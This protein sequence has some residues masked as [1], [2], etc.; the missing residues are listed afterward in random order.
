[1]PDINSV[2]CDHII[3][4]Y[5]WVDTP[6]SHMAFVEGVGMV[7]KQCIQA[8]GLTP[9]IFKDCHICGGKAGEHTFDCTYFLTDH[10]QFTQR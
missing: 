1:M 7:C 10:K 2:S 5:C 3:C 9:K 8:R 6:E 4:P